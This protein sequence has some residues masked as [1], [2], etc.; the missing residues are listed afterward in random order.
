MAISWVLEIT[1]AILLF[2]R[3]VRHHFRLFFSFALFTALATGLKLFAVSNY[4]SYFYVYWTTEAILLLLGLAALHEVF[5]WVYE[6]FYR[7]LWFQFVYYGAVALVLLVT[8]RNAIVN[9]PIQ[10]HPVIGLILD[11]GT[12]VN[13]IQLAI[14]AVFSALLKPLFVPF[15]RYPFGIV[16]GFGISAVGTLVGYLALSIFGTKVQSFTQN[17]SAVAYILALGLWIMAFFRQEPE[18]RAW[19]PPMPPA[20]MLRIARAYLKVLR[21]G[22]KDDET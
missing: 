13:F 15:R 17:A 10:A 18:E 8:I 2:R 19:T 22:R 14:V 12:V 1:L 3:G 20:E 6:G 9:P 16:A 11:V 4:R 7:L 5:Y 21:P